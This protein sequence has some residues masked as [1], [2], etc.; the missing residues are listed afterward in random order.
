MLGIHSAPSAGKANCKKPSLGILLAG[1]LLLQPLPI[2]AVENTLTLPQAIKR[3]MKENPSLKVF[4]F[5]QEALN[6]ALTTAS[7][8]SAYELGLDAENFSGSGDFKNFKQAEFTVALSSTIEMGGKRKAR[9]DT[10]IR[11]QDRLRS[12]RQANSLELLG[13]VTRRYINVLAAQERVDLAIRADQLAKATLSEVRKR[14]Q[15][16]ATPEAEVRRAEAA[17]GQAHLTVSSEQNQLRYHKV[18]LVALW[19]RTVPDFVLAEGDLYRFG[20]DIDFDT[21]YARVENNPAIQVFAAEERLKD[22]ELRFAKSE[23]RTDIRWSVGIR[24]FQEQ[25]DTAVVAGFS[26]PLFSG[27][28]SSGAVRSATAAKQ[29]LGALKEAELLKIRTQLYRAFSN[30]QQAIHAAKDLRRDIVPA[31]EEA[32][33]ETRQAYQRGRYSYI[34]YVTARQELLAAQRALIEAATAALSYGADIEQLTS[35]P[36]SASQYVSPDTSGLI[37]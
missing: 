11:I 30:R 37:Q 22:A 36:L 23:A 10:V 31:L 17:A 34:D 5:R 2:Q 33:E 14:A 16:A 8:R 9:S 12:Q 15:A 27:R 7:L 4:E 20:E 6:G 28:R 1:L 29:E 35:E 25:R 19:G 13:E 26:V 21:L 18:A 32:L 3:V 24:R